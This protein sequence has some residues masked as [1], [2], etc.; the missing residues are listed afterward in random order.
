MYK[1]ENMLDCTIIPYSMQIINIHKQAEIKK[2]QWTCQC[3]Y[4]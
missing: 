2:E 1:L 4:L 3:T